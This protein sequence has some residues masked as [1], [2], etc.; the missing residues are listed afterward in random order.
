MCRP[1]GLQIQEIT[2]WFNKNGHHTFLKLF[3]EQVTKTGSTMRTGKTLGVPSGNWS[4]QR[5]RVQIRENEDLRLLCFIPVSH[6]LKTSS[7]SREGERRRERNGGPFHSLGGAHPHARILKP[8]QHQ[9]YGTL[10]LPFET[11]W[12]LGPFA[13]GPGLSLLERQK[14][15]KGLKI[16][17]CLCWLG[18]ILDDL[19]LR[20]KKKKKK[21][22]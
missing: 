6:F 22:K 1:K 10:S 9:F 11:L 4:L 13:A 20:F 17:L 16:T 5:L 18:Q 14:N 8:P 19:I 21:P 12:D 7:H 15:Y 3:R 2:N